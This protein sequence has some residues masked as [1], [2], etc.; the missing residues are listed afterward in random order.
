M[1]AS[2][3]AAKNELKDS[4]SSH[5]HFTKYFVSAFRNPSRESNLNQKNLSF[6]S[7][8]SKIDL[9]QQSQNSG[10][11]RTWVDKGKSCTERKVE[12]LMHTVGKTQFGQ[13]PLPAPQPKTS[14]R[15]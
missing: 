6:L 9:H 5:N 4:S 7:D 15:Q 11:Q 14:G 2:A 8:R 3:R 13:A 1:L 10:T 12:N